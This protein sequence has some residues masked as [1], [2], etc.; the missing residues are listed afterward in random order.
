ML[1]AELCLPENVNNEYVM[2]RKV[3]WRW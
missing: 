2:H 3:R 1:H